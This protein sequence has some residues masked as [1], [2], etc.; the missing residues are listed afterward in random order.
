[1]TAPRAPENPV[2]Y[3]LP[4]LLV[5]TVCLLFAEHQSPVQMHEINLDDVVA[6]QSGRLTRELAY[7]ALGLMGAVGSVYTIVLQRRRLR[8]QPAVATAL[9]ALLSWSALSLLWTDTPST[10]GKRL[11]VLGLMF[12]GAF[13][14]AL[15]WKTDQ[16]L[17]FLA[18]SSGLQIGVGVVAEIAHGYFTPW[19]ADYRFAGTLPWNSQGYVCLTC[20]LSSLCMARLTRRG[21]FGYSLLAAAGM[22]FL[23]LTRSRGGLI[24]FSLAAVLYAALTL[25]AKRRVCAALLTGCL[26]LL[27]IMSGA[28]PVL[29]GLLNRGGEGMDTLTGRAPLWDELMTY[30]HQRPM[31]G[32]GYEGFWKV[33]RIDDISGDQLWAIDQAH[34]GYIEGLL[35]LGWIGAT[36]HTLTLLVC[37]GAGAMLFRRGG[38]Y[39][40]FLTASFCLVYLIGG[41][42]EALFVVKTSQSSFFFA[43][44]L[45]RLSV[46][47]ESRSVGA[48]VGRAALG[49]KKVVPVA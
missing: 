8:W 5:L 42:I 30:A 31:T 49:T 10:T 46:E 23:L 45:C 19:S 11:F 43:L 41:V 37:F 24:A 26:A 4:L 27:L 3:S 25:D 33:E 18:L 20:A 32:Y 13:G 7:I 1:M 44:L 29:A 36:L 34:S 40:Y 21:R 15:S 35:E 47:P 48:L 2:R 38:D 22:L 14:I 12:L 16:I 17:R 28:G 6:K 9:V 39:V